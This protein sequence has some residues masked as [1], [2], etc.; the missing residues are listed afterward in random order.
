LVVIS[1]RQ[2]ANNDLGSTYAGILS[3]GSTRIFPCAFSLSKE[4]HVRG[5]YANHHAARGFMHSHDHPA[6]GIS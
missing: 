4:Q 2:V 5:T 6:I 1:A 3:V